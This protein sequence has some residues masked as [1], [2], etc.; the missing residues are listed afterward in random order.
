MNMNKSYIDFSS[1][2]TS[3]FKAKWSDL[4]LDAD[5]IN[6]MIENNSINTYF[7]VLFEPV[8]NG[9]PVSNREFIHGFRQY[10]YYLVN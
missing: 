3:K 9:F 5:D 2:K 10:A 6:K 8:E 1:I 4:S 7:A